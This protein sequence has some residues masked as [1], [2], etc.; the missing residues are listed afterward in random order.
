MKKNCDTTMKFRRFGVKKAPSSRNKKTAEKFYLYRITRPPRSHRRE[1]HRVTLSTKDIDPNKASSYQETRGRYVTP[2][3]PTYPTWNTFRSRRPTTRSPTPLS[4]SHES[5]GKRAERTTKGA[6][7]LSRGAGCSRRN[8][9]F[10]RESSHGSS[11]L[12]II[13]LMPRG[14]GARGTYAEKNVFAAVH[15]K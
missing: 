3:C 14:G 13:N 5:A 9:M 12:Q 11:L 8:A 15:F 10:T 1:P 2:W 7:R 6:S 4:L